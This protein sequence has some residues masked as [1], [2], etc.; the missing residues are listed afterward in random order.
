MTVAQ[1]SL[2]RI[3][4]CRMLTSSA[5][6]G[7]DI[8]ERNDIV[9]VSEP[10]ALDMGIST[11]GPSRVGSWRPMLAGPRTGAIGAT[12]VV[13]DPHPTK[14]TSASPK[15]KIPRAF[16]SITAAAFRFTEKTV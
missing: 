16:V 7:D 12:E 3:V 6:R 1:G 10:S 2:V 14:P 4:R 8:G 15:R 13:E 9:P 11:L 5:V